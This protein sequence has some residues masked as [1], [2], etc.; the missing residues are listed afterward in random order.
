[1]HLFQQPEMIIP[2]GTDV[3]TQ[4]FIKSDSA[5]KRKLLR[6]LIRE[7]DLLRLMVGIN[8]IHFL[9]PKTCCERLLIWTMIPIWMSCAPAEKGKRVTPVNIHWDWQSGLITARLLWL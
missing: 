7:K 2:I 3:P 8:L 6:T 1:M 4:Y 5:S 9:S